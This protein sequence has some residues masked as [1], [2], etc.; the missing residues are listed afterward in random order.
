[1]FELP[2]QHL[3]RLRTRSD[4]LYVSQNRTVLATRRDGFINAESDHGFFVQSARLL[5]RYEYFLNDIPH[6]RTD[7]PTS[8][9]IPGW[10]TTSPLPRKRS[11]T[12]SR[13]VREERQLSTP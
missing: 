3:V 13:R 7:C 2:P 8:S 11:T 4:T 1:M 10:A 12:S 5:S 6:H 9:S